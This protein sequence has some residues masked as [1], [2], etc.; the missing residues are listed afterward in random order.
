V[1]PFA[2]TTIKSGLKVQ[3]ELD[4]SKDQPALKPTGEQMGFTK[5][6]RSNFHGW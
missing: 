4:G 2:A 5:I 3:A 6:E 1:L